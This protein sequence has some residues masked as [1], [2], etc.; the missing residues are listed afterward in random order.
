[1]RFDLLLATTRL[2][3]SIVAYCRRFPYVVVEYYYSRVI[4]PAVDVSWSNT[5]RDDGL[6]SDENSYTAPAYVFFNESIPDRALSLAFNMPHTALLRTQAKDP[7]FPRTPFSWP[8]C[9]RSLTSVLG[10][11]HAVGSQCLHF[12][13]YILF[14][15]RTIQ[16]EAALNVSNAYTMVLESAVRDN[17]Y[18]GRQV[19]YRLPARRP[20]TKD[21]HQH[22]L[23]T[24]QD[25]RC[26]PLALHLNIARTTPLLHTAVLVC[27]IPIPSS[28]LW[29]LTGAKRPLT[30]VLPI[31]DLRRE[32]ASGERASGVPSSSGR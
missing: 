18:F 22:G 11:T 31:V 4:L 26:L 2:L 1:M 9:T 12:K 16:R 15:H 7:S 32:R 21:S 25:C 17:L 28:S 8:G 10:W 13:G 29:L 19:Q 30:R 23:V 14:L 6:Q 20:L 27:A 24:A 5:T 3:S